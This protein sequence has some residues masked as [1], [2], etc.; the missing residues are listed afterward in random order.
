MRVYS[1][2]LLTTL[3]HFYLEVLFDLDNLWVR[4]ECLSKIM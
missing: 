3:N 4:T 1:R 2:N